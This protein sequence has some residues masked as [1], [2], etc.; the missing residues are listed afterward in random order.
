MIKTFFLLNHRYQ[1][2]R[3]FCKYNVPASGSKYI[4][5]FCREFWMFITLLLLLVREEVLKPDLWCPLYSAE[6]YLAHNLS[7]A[8]VAMFLALRS[9]K[10]EPKTEIITLLKYPLYIFSNEIFLLPN[11]VRNSLGAEQLNSAHKCCVHVATIIKKR[12]LIGVTGSEPYVTLAQT[13]SK[14]QYRFRWDL[15]SFQGII[16]Q[17]LSPNS[18]N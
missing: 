2:Y 18:G 17:G 10:I 14:I 7:W 4:Y 11:P 5:P 16:S 8:K 3:L 9:Y 12:R 15:S 1:K 13:S 6:N